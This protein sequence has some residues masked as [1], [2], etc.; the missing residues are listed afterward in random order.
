MQ[1]VTSLACKLYVSS[2]LYNVNNI[3]LTARLKTKSYNAETICIDKNK[4][5]KHTGKAKGTYII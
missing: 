2:Q 3:R 5:H 4:M 1:C